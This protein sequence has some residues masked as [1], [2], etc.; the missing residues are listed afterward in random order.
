ME[1]VPDTKY[2]HFISCS[3]SHWLQICTIVS[4]TMGAAMK[5]II[6]LLVVV[7]ST[8]VARSIGS[9]IFNYLRKSRKIKQGRNQA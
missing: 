2:V 7:D 8:A 1:P 9:R 3:N 4:C 5:V 6:L